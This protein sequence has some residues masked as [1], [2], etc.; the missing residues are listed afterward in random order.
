MRRCRWWLKKWGLWCVRQPYKYGYISNLFSVVINLWWTYGWNAED[1]IRADFLRKIFLEIR[2]KTKI[3]LYVK[4]IIIRNCVILH[5]VT[6]QN[7]SPSMRK[8]LLEIHSNKRWTQIRI[9]ERT[10]IGPG[11]RRKTV[12]LK[13]VYEMA[14]AWKR[15]RT[16]IYKRENIH[17]PAIPL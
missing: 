14:G 2:K 9:A 1:S 16:P 10:I 17:Q 7:I 4:I 8:I 3:I 6:S 12:R 15:R 13:K 11:C 5:E